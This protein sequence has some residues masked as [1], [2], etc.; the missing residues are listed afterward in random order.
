VR[1]RLLSPALEEI[2]EAALWFDRQRVGLGY[3]F[4]RCVDATLDRIEDNPYGFAKSEFATPNVELRFTIVH[5]FQYVIHF[6]VEIDEVQVVAVSHAAR[7][8]G[9]WLRRTKRE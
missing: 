4:W 1:V 9:Y 5:R 2:T 7:E 3:E 8:P 6:L